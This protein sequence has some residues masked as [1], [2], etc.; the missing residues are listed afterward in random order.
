[1]YKQAI[2]S[3][4]LGEIRNRFMVYQGPRDLDGKFESAKQIKGLSG[5]ELA[6]PQDFADRA[7]LDALLKKYGYE[8]AALNFRCRRNDKGLRGSF[9][10]S[11]SED[12][13]EVVQ[14]MKTCIDCAHEMGVRYITT[15]PLNE[16][17]DYLFEMDYSVAYDNIV[18]AFREI[19]D[20]AAERAPEIR[21]CIEYK[22]SEPRTRCFIA[23]AGEAL[24]LCQEVD[25]ENIGVNLD[26]GHA[27]QAGER[28]AQS[29]AMLHK[30]GKLFYVHVN[31]NDR[32]G[33]WDMIPGSINF[34]DFVEFFYYLRRIGYS[35]WLTYD[36]YP[37]ENPAPEVFNS[38]FQAV[39]KL[40]EIAGR[41]DSAKMDQLMYER[42]PVAVMNYLYT[43]L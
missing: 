42:N 34:W 27:L 28:P 32:I 6:Y 30:A 41:I 22:Y 15:C 37:K 3:N 35:G 23:G 1:M 11:H 4:F 36:V 43:L 12:V 7:H 25:R 9:T 17:H 14:E 31:D 13:D 20:Y 2:I 16:G 18:R 24:A 39:S 40:I 8:A 38:S 26:I 5:L 21:I 10:S 29:A 19:G 33:D